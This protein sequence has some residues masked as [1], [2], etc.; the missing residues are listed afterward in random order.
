MEVECYLSGYSSFLPQSKNMTVTLHFS[1]GMNVCLVC[2][3]ALPYDGL[4]TS[5]PAGRPNPLH[6][7]G[8]TMDGRSSSVIGLMTIRLEKLQY[9]MLCLVAQKEVYLNLH[10]FLRGHVSK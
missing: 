6:G 2:V 1:F 10:Y 9:L 7:A 8:V 4:V 3:S 5:T